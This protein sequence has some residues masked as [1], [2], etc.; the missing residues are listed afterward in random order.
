MG[1]CVAILGLQL[2]FWLVPN[3]ISGAVSISLLGFF[4]GPMSATGMSIAT[5]IYPKQ[6]QPTAL[7]KL[8]L[9]MV[10]SYGQRLRQTDIHQALFSSSLK[11]RCIVPSPHGRNS[12]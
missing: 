7:G 6:I 12:E 5:K 4:Y 3:I 11:Q 10:D 8:K 9:A 1:Y 2:I